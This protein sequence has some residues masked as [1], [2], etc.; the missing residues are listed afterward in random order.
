[1]LVNT[2]Q[3]VTS[4]KFKHSDYGF[5]FFIGYQED[6]IVKPLWIILPQMRGYI[7]YFETVAKTCLFWLK[8]TMYWINTIK[9]GMWLKI[10]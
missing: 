5:K 3:I 10:N 2:E 4:D 6:E 9:F 7:K 8:M 1:M